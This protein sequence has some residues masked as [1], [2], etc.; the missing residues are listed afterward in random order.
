MITGG[1]AACRGRVGIAPPPP[2][3]SPPPLLNP[4]P[5]R[6]RQIYF[7]CKYIGTHKYVARMIIVSSVS[8]FQ[9]AW[10]VS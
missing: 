10:Q 8:F 1:A 2:Q 5:P 3:I 6:R 7:F 9:M 4:I